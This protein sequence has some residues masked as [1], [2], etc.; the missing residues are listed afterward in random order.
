VSVTGGSEPGW[1]VPTLTFKGELIMITKLEMLLSEVR[2]KRKECLRES[3]LLLA[4]AEAFQE[5][6][7]SLEKAVDAEKKEK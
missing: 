1:C 4:K 7:D 5:S 3:S 6:A 2:M